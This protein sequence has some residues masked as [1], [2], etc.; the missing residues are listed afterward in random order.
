[1]IA[2]SGAPDRLAGGCDSGQPFLFGGAV[3]RDTYDRFA[4][5]DLKPIHLPDV[6]EIARLTYGVQ[7]EKRFFTG[8]IT[9]MNSKSLV[10]QQ[11]LTGSLMGFLISHVSGKDVHISTLAVHPSHRRRG[12]GTA[13]LQRL[14]VMIPGQVTWTVARESRLESHRF[15]ASAGFRAVAVSR[16]HFDDTGED[17]YLMVHS[18]NAEDMRWI[19]GDLGQRFRK[20]AA[21]VKRRSDS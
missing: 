19:D 15:L 5:V 6:M 4:I 7:Q 21:T 9:A 11:V 13:I 2:R 1:L 3:I 8:R 16:S 18:A 10:A 20:D 17:G 14:M 12:V